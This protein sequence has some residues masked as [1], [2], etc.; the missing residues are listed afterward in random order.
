MN[1]YFDAE[2]IEIIEI[3]KFRCYFKFGMSLH[4]LM[5]KH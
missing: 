2:R 1:Y 5:C 3:L 4:K